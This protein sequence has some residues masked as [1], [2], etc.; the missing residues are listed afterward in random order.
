M[1]VILLK[2]SPRNTNKTKTK[3]Q[4]RQLLFL[5]LKKDMSMALFF[6]LNNFKWQIMIPNSFMKF[7]I[8]FSFDY[9]GKLVPEQ[10]R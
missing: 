3:S 1:N 2:V 4:N 8:S 6:F 10:P 7:V 5:L 9:I